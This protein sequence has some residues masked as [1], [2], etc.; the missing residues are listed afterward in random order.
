[1]N[2]IVYEPKRVCHVTPEKVQGNS[3]RQPR[4]SYLACLLSPLRACVRTFGSIHAV[5]RHKERYQTGNAFALLSNVFIGSIDAKA[6]S[7]RRH[8]HENS[9]PIPNNYLFFP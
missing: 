3:A 8:F 4:V 9:K 6:L 5:Q 7:F 2:D 1:M